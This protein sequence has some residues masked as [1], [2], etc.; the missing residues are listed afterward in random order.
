MQGTLVRSL[1]WEDPTCCR[2]TK[3]VR[4]CVCVCHNYWASAL[5][6]ARHNSWAH[7]PQLLKPMC[8]ELVLLKR[9]ATTLRSLHSARK[10]SPCSLQLEKALA[11]Q[12]RHNTAAASLQSCPSLCDPTDGSPP[13]SAVPGILQT[14]TLEWVAI[15]FSSAWK[16][17][18][19]VNECYLSNILR[20]ASEV[21]WS[22]SHSVMSDSLWSYGLSAARLL[23][24]WNSPDKNTGVG[25]HFLLQGPFLT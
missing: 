20:T 25:C 17:K 12:W 5:E 24:P 19:K 8:Q 11:Q 9:E 23:C 1:L 10:G 18:A 13:G 15:S 2:A 6:L 14:K 22:E 4:V 3:C 16:W 21:K 7:T